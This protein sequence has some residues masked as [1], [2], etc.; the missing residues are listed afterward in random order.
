MNT[1]N[2]TLP[3][4]ASAGGADGAA[5][6]PRRARAVGARGT[7]LIEVLMAVV[8]SALVAASVA[9]MLTMLGGALREQ[10]MLAN[11][12]IRVAGGHAR[13][14]DHV[15]RAR[16]ILGMSSTQLVLWVPSEDFVA[17]DDF[18]EA[19][20][21]IHANEIRWYRWN[22]ATKCV[23]LSRTADPDASTVHAMSADWGALHAS[24]ASGSALQ[25]VP[26]FDGLTSATFH[27]HGFDPCATRRV[28]LDLVFDAQH[29]GQSLRL[30]E[31]VSFL[32]KHKDCP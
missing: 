17:S 1:A 28:N 30:S 4:S 24:L 2:A 7:T 20:D 26:V 29:G 6:R 5:A 31:A 18:E 22:D 16:A 21:E 15:L 14:S 13:F 10:D 8:V 27:H 19:Y 9:S 32:Q 25:I 23:E 11:H 3:R 12:V